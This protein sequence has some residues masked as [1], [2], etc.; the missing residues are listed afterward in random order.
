MGLWTEKAPAIDGRGKVG[1]TARS[2]IRPFPLC[3]IALS[4][5]ASC[6]H[7]SFNYSQS[8]FF[9]QGQQGLVHLRQRFVRRCHGKGPSHLT[10]R[11]KLS[12][13]GLSDQ[14]GPSHSAFTGRAERSLVAL[15]TFGGLLIYGKD[16]FFDAK[17]PQAPGIKTFEMDQ[18]FEPGARNR[19]PTAGAA[20]KMREVV[21]LMSLTA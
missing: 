18:S 11:G 15:P 3:I 8:A 20:L 14:F 16:L 1:R 19:R 4:R 17:A 13:A 7:L 9:G 2:R 10:G 21:C 12:R 5:N 6:L